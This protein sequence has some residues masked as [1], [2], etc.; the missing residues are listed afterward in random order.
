MLTQLTTLA[1]MIK[2]LAASC[3]LVLIGGGCTA[4]ARRS[5]AGP[6][7]VLS[8]SQPSA[9]AP[10]N[11]YASLP[12]GSSIPQSSDLLIIGAWHLVFQEPAEVDDLVYTMETP[13][14]GIQSIGFSSKQLEELD[15]TSGG[16]ECDVAD[17]PLGY[18]SRSTSLVPYENY[19]HV[20]PAYSEI[21]GYFYVYSHPQ[22]TCS[23]FAP[24]QGLEIEE[25][26]ELGDTI[27]STLKTS[28]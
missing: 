2:L 9:P 7:I 5:S 23:V 3:A 16:S 18:L 24:V 20:A 4:P 10:G 28:P 26:Q 15:R 19:G 17:A 21:G 27:L 14:D 11:E 1:A 8:T 13:V 22:A 25:F 6:D 12:S